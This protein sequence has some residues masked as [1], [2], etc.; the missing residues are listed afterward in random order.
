MMT[1]FLKRW[2]CISDGLLDAEP[3]TTTALSSLSSSPPM[4]GHD[5]LV[6][7]HAD[8]FGLLACD[9]QEEDELDFCAALMDPEE[10]R[11]YL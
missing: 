6:L 8:P 10:C 1:W 5:M 3:D 11:G 4:S 2:N 9:E 7:K